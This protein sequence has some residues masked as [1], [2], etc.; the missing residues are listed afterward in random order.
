MAEAILR[1]KLAH[2]GLEGIQVKSAGI[3][4]EE[5]FPAHPLAIGIC[6]EHGVKLN[7]HRSRQLT[8][9]MME[10]AEIILGMTDSHVHWLSNSFPEK[11]ADIHLMKRY[12]REEIFGDREVADPY[13]MDPAQYEL[14]Y[15]ELENEL[16]RIV[17]IL[18]AKYHREK[19]C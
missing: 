10:E 16:E 2:R 17:Q 6:L 15:S 7:R 3:A 9:D 1:Q 4:A 13:G 12:G 18:D 11:A 5:G 19:M 14:C 8:F